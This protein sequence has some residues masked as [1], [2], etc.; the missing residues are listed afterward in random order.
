MPTTIDRAEVQRMLGAGAQLLE[1]LATDEYAEEHIRRAENL[2]LAELRAETA[3]RF[4]PKRP[5]IVYCDDR[6]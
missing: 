3:A 6:E 4:D 2:P 1:V 5:V